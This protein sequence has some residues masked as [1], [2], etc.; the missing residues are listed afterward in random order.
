[1]PSDDRIQGARDALQAQG[2]GF[3]AAVE[4]GYAQVRAYLAAH[5]TGSDE[6]ARETALELGAFAGGRIDVGRFAAVLGTSRVLDQHEETVVRRCADV[7]DEVLTRVGGVLVCQVGEGKDLRSTVEDALAMVGRAF[8]AALVFQAVKAGTYRPDQHEPALRTY[9]F[10][11][12]SRHERLLAPPLVVSLEGAELNVASL[13]EYLDGRQKIVLIV[14]GASASAPLA[15]LI[16]PHLF[17][18]QA[19][20]AAELARLAAVEGPGVAALMPSTAARFVH[21]PA[22]ARLD[23]SFVGADPPRTSVGGWSGWQQGEELALLRQ[24]A[25]AGA[26]A[27]QVEARIRERERDGDGDGTHADFGPVGVDEL[28]SWMLAQAGFTGGAA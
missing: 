25:A 23:I 16:T 20:N 7:M 8:S 9:P 21:D 22:T 1:M 10:R 12:W 11:R 13:A 14:E 3:R 24:F 17:V 26:M 19:E 28:S 6:R 5:G 2:A 27:A 15:R 18:M 4:T